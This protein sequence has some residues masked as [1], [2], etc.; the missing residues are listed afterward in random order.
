MSLSI[1]IGFPSFF[2]VSLFLS[3]CV[4]VCLFKCAWCSLVFGGVRAWGRSHVIHSNGQRVR[5]RGENKAT[6]HPFR[7]TCKRKSPRV[8][9]IYAVPF[10]S[11]IFFLKKKEE[12][13]A[14]ASRT[15]TRDILLSLC[16]NAIG[17][18]AKEEEKE[19]KDPINIFIH[20]AADGAQETQNGPGGR[21][22]SASNSINSRWVESNRHSFHQ[23][24]DVY[25]RIC[26]EERERDRRSSSSS[27]LWA[28]IERMSREK[29]ER[30]ARPFILHSPSKNSWILL[31]LPPYLIWPNGRERFFF[32]F[33][34]VC[35]ETNETTYGGYWLGILTPYIT[36]QSLIVSSF[37]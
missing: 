3:V 16:S 11:S 6:S 7:V 2:S 9:W 32:F 30:H 22:P 8:R 35:A 23:S 12:Y 14:A 19:D 10:F 36:R 4:Y 5:E 20:A 21:P 26:I 24:I 13:L 25:T 18:T 34:F 28:H 17:S 31:F 37:D 15:R 33:L 27:A 1:C 29:G